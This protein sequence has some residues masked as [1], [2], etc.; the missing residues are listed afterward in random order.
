MKKELRILNTASG[1]SMMAAGLFG[2]LYAV[3]V[4]Q[5]GGDLLTAGAAYSAFCI[6]GGVFL[7]IISR[8]E[9]RVQK[10]ERILILG[11]VL[12]LAGFI[13]YLLVKTPIHLFIVEAILGISTAIMIPAFDSFYSRHLEP[14]KF[15]SQWGLWESVNLVVPGVGAF[16][17]GF[18]ARD[19]G[20]RSLFLVMVFFSVIG[21]I[22]SLFL[23]HKKKQFVSQ[24]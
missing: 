4:E 1:F 9:D 6:A 10:Q 2:P 3:F 5:I 13:G 20:F 22:V 15:A 23:L 12:Q 16:I 21:L 24:I 19:Y 14:G 7:F 17:G 11:Y 8:F 18:I